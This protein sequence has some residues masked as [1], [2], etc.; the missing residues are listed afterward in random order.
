MMKQLPGFMAV[1]LP[2]WIAGAGPVRAGE[3]AP[4]PYKKGEIRKIPVFYRTDGFSQYYTA[5]YPL[6][7]EKLEKE[8]VDP[9]VQGGVSGILWGISA[10]S[11]V[12]FASKTGQLLG[13]GLTPEIWKKMRKGDYNAYR[14]LKHLIDSGQDPLTI[15][16]ARAHQFDRKL[17]AYMH[18]NKEYGPVKSWTW[19]LLTDDFSK[20]HPEYRIPGSL[21][22][23]FTH[24]EV[25]DRKLAILRDAAQTGVDGVA[26]NL[27]TQFFAD[28]EAGR[29]VL[30]QFIRDVRKMLDEMGTKRG[31]R[32]ELWVRIPFRGAYERGIDWETWM[33]E[34]LID[35]LSA[36]KGWPSSD[37]FDVSM[38]PFIAF[39]RKINSPCKIHGFIWQALGIVD[40]DPSPHGKRRYGKP[41]LPGMY[42]AQALLHNYD[43]CDGIELG[44]ATPYQWR[45]FYG[46]LG[47]PDKIRYADKWYMV[48]LRPTMPIVFGTPKEDSAHKTERNV[49]SLRIADDI[50]GASEHHKA[51]QA[52]VIIYCR[53]LDKDEK[54][55]LYVND[56]GPVVISAETL[57][58][59]NQG[60]PVSTAEIHHNRARNVRTEHSTSFL[61]TPNWWKQGQ[62]KIPIPAEWLIRGR[63][64]LDF[65][66]TASPTE[67]PKRLE[68]TWVEVALQYANKNP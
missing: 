24:K 57:S 7:K 44:F 17:L 25:R 20:Q 8:M 28:P 55:D 3:S 46:E 11:R 40:T 2:L 66:Y 50:R 15:A 33:K 27:M 18:V 39:K 41:K 63:N 53:S 6:T 45:A 31:R 30:T 26:L 68:I 14:N 16:A 36:Y 62:K 64:V 19:M 47:T 48:D 10:G 32:L 38:E 51:V 42:F 5:Q 35:C 21:L 29:P 52:Q 58:H 65:R 4:P 12:T 54:I 59:Q 49:V 37:Y 34:G 22:L 60:A 1:C 23:D 9:L 13:D 43:G 56:K 61:N 67:K